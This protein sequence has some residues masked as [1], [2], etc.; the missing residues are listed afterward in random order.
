MSRK[1]LLCD[2]DGVL[3]RWDRLAAS[4]RKVEGELNVP[5]A[6]LIEHAFERRTLK[7]VV[8]GRITQNEWVTRIAEVLRHEYGVEAS[9]RLIDCWLADPGEVDRDVE[10]ILRN[11]KDRGWRLVLVTNATDKLSTDMTSLG[12]D[13]LFDV[14]VNSSEFGFAKPDPQF[15]E[16]ALKMTDVPASNCIF[17][18]DRERNVEP[19]TKLGMAGVVFTDAD[20]LELA[21]D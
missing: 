1:A 15:Y 17:V 12:L 21:L 7:A 2:F 4:F 20:S 19:A 18:D 10:R 16:H 13:D 11:S 6:V 14:I 3:R 8:T 5:E 9:R